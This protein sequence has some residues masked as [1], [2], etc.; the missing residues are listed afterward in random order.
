MGMIEQIIC[1]YLTNNNGEH[2]FTTMSSEDG[3]FGPNNLVINMN[4]SA[5]IHDLVPF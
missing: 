2:S 4:F 1:P 5:H 3:Q